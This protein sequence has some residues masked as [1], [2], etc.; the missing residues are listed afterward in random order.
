V[1]HDGVLGSYAIIAF[2]GVRTSLVDIWVNIVSWL[3]KPQ[4]PKK[5]AARAP[6]ALLPTPDGTANW[7]LVLYLGHADRRR[8]SRETP[9]TPSD[10][11][12]APLTLPV[13]APEVDPAVLGADFARETT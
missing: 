1:P 5:M 10:L 2:I 3:Y 12:R 6:A 11:D 9:E 4:G 7:E 13:S 8:R